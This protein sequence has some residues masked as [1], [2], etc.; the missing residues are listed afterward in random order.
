MKF[1]FVLILFVLLLSIFKLSYQDILQDSDSSTC[2]FNGCECAIDD[3]NNGGTISC[4]DDFID[5]PKRQENYKLESVKYEK[6][7]IAAK[8]NTIPDD[9]FEGLFIEELIFPGNDINKIGKN[10]FKGLKGV[11]TIDLSENCLGCVDGESKPTGNEDSSKEIHITSSLIDPTTFDSIKNSIKVIRLSKNKLNKISFA[12]LNRLFQNLDELRTLE[13]SSNSLK[14]MPNLSGLK[15]LE[16]LDLELNQITSLNSKDPSTSQHVLPSSLKVLRLGKNGLDSIEAHWFSELKDLTSLSLNNNEISKIAENAFINL[17][18]LEHLDLS[19]NYIKHIPSKC[20]LKL[21]SL[22]SLDLSGQKYE[23]ESIGDYAFD[24]ESARSENKL[25]INLFGNKISKISNKA[26]C[27]RNSAEQ[28]SI[29]NIQTLNLGKNEL[30]NVSA[31]IFKQLH[32]HNHNH[33]AHL[34]LPDMDC[35][36]DITYLAKHFNI[37]ESQCKMTETLTT[38]KMQDFICLDYQEDAIKERCRSPEFSCGGITKPGIEPTKS[39][40]KPNKINENTNVIKGEDPTTINPKAVSLTNRLLSNTILSLLS[41]L[42][43]SFLIL[44]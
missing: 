35:S 20:F 8:I 41:S 31:C 40:E 9:R 28:S 42:V 26:F 32:S 34:I 23:I 33:K 7:E 12:D 21:G 18:N 3:N 36:C 44:K 37:K 16:L 13:L 10:A 2:I 38:V 17:K 11:T 30:K 24:R 15:K 14:N 5:F 43:L 29:M 39:N 22:K 6:I 4:E 25:S 1:R 27:A 19:N